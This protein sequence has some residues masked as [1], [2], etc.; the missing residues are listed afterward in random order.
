M[1]RLL[2]LGAAILGLAGLACLGLYFSRGEGAGKLTWEDPVVRKSLMS[3]VYK[4]YGD[5]SV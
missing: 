3:F 2:Q 5:A 1:K 4:I